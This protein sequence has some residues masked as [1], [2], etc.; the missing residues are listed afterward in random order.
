VSRNGRAGSNRPLARISDIETKASRSAERKSSNSVGAEFEASSSS[1]S[2]LSASAKGAREAG[3]VSSAEIVSTT[4]SQET[5]ESFTVL[6]KDRWEL[7]DVFAPALHGQ[8]A[9]E[10]HFCKID[11]GQPTGSVRALLQFY[12]KDLILDPEESS[13]FAA[14]IFKN[15][16]TNISVAKALVAKHLRSINPEAL[17]GRNDGR[18]NLAASIVHYEVRRD[19][20]HR[21]G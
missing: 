19:G 3:L 13:G 12:P 2:L 5:V 1:T 10:D 21:S 11:I 16:P 14:S 20:D 8:Y 17:S 9:P 4:R 7:R 15:K 18:I 6:T